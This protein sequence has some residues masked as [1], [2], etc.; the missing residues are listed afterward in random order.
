VAW[1]SVLK[2]CTN[3]INVVI[4]FIWTL[5]HQ[6]I[7]SILKMFTFMYLLKVSNLLQLRE[8]CFL[9]LYNILTFQ[10]MKVFRYVSDPVAFKIIKYQLQRIVV[11]LE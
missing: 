1:T 8:F 4:I 6:T 10:V 5:E 7:M 3:I 11:V 9:I 2:F